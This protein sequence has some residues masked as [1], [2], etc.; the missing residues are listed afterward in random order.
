MLY[1]LLHGLLLGDVNE[2]G[3]DPDDFPLHPDRVEALQPVMESARV[4]CSF[5]RCFHVD[6]GFASGQDSPVGRLE[7]GPELRDNLRHRPTEVALYRDA[8]D[9]RRLLVDA[10]EPEIT[11]YV[12]EPYGRSGLQRVENAEG[13]GSL[14][15]G[16]M[17]RL[18]QSRRLGA[19]VHDGRDADDR[20]LRPDDGRH[21]E[22]YLNLGAIVS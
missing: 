19:V 3:S 22:S 9:R 1:L 7:L 2:H 14:L 12:G 6:D 8:V 15:L 18:H 10:H 4:L 5:G 13:L 16:L 17:H 20:S 21:G 11:I